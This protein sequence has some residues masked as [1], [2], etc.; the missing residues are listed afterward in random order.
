MTSVTSQNS[1]NAV[2]LLTIDANDQPPVSRIN[3]VNRARG[4]VAQLIYANRERNR[5]NTAIQGAMDG[6]PPFSRQ[7]LQSQG[8]LWRT[9]VNWM[10]AKAL[11]SAALCP[12]YDLFAS[13]K[14]YFEVRTELGNLDQQEMWSNY[15]TEIQDE[16]L[17]GWS[18]FDFN[19]QAML[20][21]MVGFGKGF[22]MWMDKSDWHFKFISQFKVLV[23]NGTDGYSE[24]LEVVVL[25]QACRVDQ[26]WK[27]IRNPDAA[28]AMGW[29]RRATLT[30]IANA[31]PE[32]VTG[33]AG[34]QWNYD[35][36]QQMMRDHDISM[37]VRCATVQAAHILVKEFDGRVSH[38]ICTENGVGPTQQ[39]PGL[40]G[41]ND[42]MCKRVGAFDSFSS[43]LATFFL[44]TL[45]GSWNGAA[46]LGNQ[47]YAP[48]EAKNR[49]RCAEVD[50]AFIR[51][52]I[53]LQAKSASA[54]QKVG[55]IQMGAFNIIPDGFDV[56]Q[57]TIMGDIAGLISVQRDLD[58]LIASNT[59]VYRQ[60]LDKPQGNPRTAREVTLD[61]Q[62]SATLSN[63]AINRFYGNLD[64]FGTELFR[65][66]K[67]DSDFKKKLE[68]K[69][70]PL[71]CLDHIKYVRAFRNI[72][73]GSMF[74]RQQVF[75]TTG[76]LVP[77]MNE[78]GRNNWLSENI[79]AQAG[80]DASARWNPQPDPSA[81]PDDQV[82]IATGQVADM[83]I[84]VPAVVTASQNPV[85]FASTFIDAGEQ[86]LASIQHG[87]H[88]VEVLAFM[89]LDLH[90]IA[91]H[92]QR[93]A[94]DPSRQPAVQALSQRFESLGK[95]T[96]ELQSQV[97]KIHDQQQQYQQAA[98]PDNPEAQA[99][100]MKTQTEMGVTTAKAQHGMQLSE[101]KQQHHASMQEQKQQHSQALQEQKQAHTQALQT[102]KQQHDMALAVQKQK[103]DEA[104]AAE[105]SKHERSETKKA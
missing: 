61:A 99:L 102:M 8:Q 5:V 95:A 46:G 19:L 75:Q 16:V 6:N 47:I 93:M 86:S 74:M 56:Q 66:L 48:I 87:G 17:K 77:M 54:T 33:Q 27:P 22:L 25:R 30:A 35:Q 63:S 84:G 53:T 105:K 43:V 100:M 59:G 68:S 28:N 94:S 9:N 103:F 89:P 31:V 57:S 2:D 37:G 13:N 1:S 83:K 32:F 39:S 60:R 24:D 58:E 101:A 10:E 45:D 18:G 50:A 65:R 98:Q 81:L 72:G 97:Q 20:D 38:Y 91:S 40:P 52:A 85:I 62:D 67:K 3:D 36:V 49:L 26:L 104:L 41:E 34:M 73:N 78:K 80:Q 44:E 7:K 96:N 79:A 69:G 64:R 70:V 82:A 92:L 4:I 21:N 14:Y 76:P 88:P 15:I 23:P 51:G 90:A 11:K 55:L 12:Y 29:N 71:E 42:F